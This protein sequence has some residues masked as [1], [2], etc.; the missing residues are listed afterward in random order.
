GE[1]GGR[2]A[3]GGGAN[4]TFPLSPSGPQ[5]APRERSDPSPSVLDRLTSLV[6]AS[7]VMPSKQDDDLS[8]FSLLETIREFALERLIA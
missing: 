3:P 8:R 6:E 1:E 7:L 4:K 2:F 5:A